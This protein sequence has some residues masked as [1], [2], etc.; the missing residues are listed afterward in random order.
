[1]PGAIEP[2]VAVIVSEAGEDGVAVPFAGEMLSQEPPEVVVA[3][4][5]NDKDPPPV[6]KTCNC[7]VSA[8]L[9]CVAVKLTFCVSIP[10]AAGVPGFTVSV[11]ATVVVEGIALG[12]VMVTVP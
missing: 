5:V 11:T 4:A 10:S 7:C 6:F 12:A 1:M 2:G 3:L 8:P 9:P